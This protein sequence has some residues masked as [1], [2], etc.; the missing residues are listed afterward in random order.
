M[1]NKV[2]KLNFI[3]IVDYG[4][5]INRATAYLIRSTFW[6]RMHILSQ[7]SCRYGA[8][9]LT[10]R[11]RIIGFN[12]RTRCYT[13]GTA[14]YAMQDTVKVTDCFLIETISYRFSRG[15]ADVIPQ[16]CW[17]NTPVVPQINQTCARAGSW[18]L[19]KDRVFPT[20]CIFILFRYIIRSRYLS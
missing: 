1:Q 11:W 14:V 20:W 3:S 4:G 6:V 15:L 7:F 5:V 17:W 9:S 19:W 12:L 8:C 18:I 16:S 10:L 2:W 13:C